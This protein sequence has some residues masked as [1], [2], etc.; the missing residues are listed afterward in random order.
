VTQ[1]TPEDIVAAAA[2]SYT[3]HFLKP[4]LARDT[5]LD[6]AEAKAHKN[7]KGSAVVKKTAKKNIG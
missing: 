4:V 7:G 6:A 3:G 1:G 5:T 2:R